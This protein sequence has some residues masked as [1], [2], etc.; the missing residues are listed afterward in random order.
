MCDE[1]GRL[2]M[3]LA[4]SEGDFQALL[5]FSKRSAVFAMRDRNPQHISDG[6]IAAAITNPQRGDV[7]E[8]CK[9]F[10]LLYHAGRMIGADADGACRDAA[11]M[12]VPMLS[13]FFLNYLAKPEEE[14]DVR[15]WT[16]WTIVETEHGPGFVLWRFRPYTP[17]Y[18][19]DQMALRLK[20]LLE[21]DRHE[22]VSIQ[23]ADYVYPIWLSNVKDSVLK[24][25]LQSACA[26]ITIH[27]HARAP[28]SH[29]Q[30]PLIFLVELTDEKAAESLLWLAEKKQS[31]ANDVA[32][33]A[34][35]EQRLFCLFI[36]RSALH[37]ETPCETHASLQRFSP[38]IAEIL[39]TYTRE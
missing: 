5:S 29:F 38:A 19:L 39:R 2:E 10:R 21:R 28:E 16:G 11:S 17:T 32:M 24:C 18:P 26:V 36:E 31:K 30:A 14:K 25:A 35:R 4:G 1:A 6:L 7:N 37:G 23:L 3:R 20:Q 22:R 15:E 33:I 8:A 9:A 13:Q 27:A 34:V 12:A